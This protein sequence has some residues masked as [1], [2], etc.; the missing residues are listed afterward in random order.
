MVYGER[1]GVASVAGL[2]TA[3][4]APL[5]HAPFWG[6]TTSDEWYRDVF[7]DPGGHNAVAD[8]CHVSAYEQDTVNQR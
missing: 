1:V 8:S 3:I 4:G 7:R 5:D 2:F 6:F